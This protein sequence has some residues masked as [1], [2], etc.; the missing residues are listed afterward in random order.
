VVQELQGAG[1]PCNGDVAAAAAAVTLE[2]AGSRASLPFCTAVLKEAMRMYPAGVAASPRC[3]GG[4]VRGS[5][6]SMQGGVMEG[7]SSAGLCVA[8]ATP[9]HASELCCPLCRMCHQAT[10]VGRYTVPAG[11]IVFPCMYS[12]HMYS[13]NFDD[14]HEVC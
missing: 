5:G 7:T 1:V 3:A 9:R 11:V 2:L 12:I 13:A 8:S 10:R 14:P 6:G 4:V